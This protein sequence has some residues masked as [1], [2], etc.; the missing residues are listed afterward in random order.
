MVK[1]RLISI[2]KEIDEK[3]LLKII[4]G[5]EKTSKLLKFKS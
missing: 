2:D 4:Y 3:E 5:N 1:K